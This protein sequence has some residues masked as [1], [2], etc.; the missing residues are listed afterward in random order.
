[1]YKLTFILFAFFSVALPI[2]ALPVPESDE[3]NA[4]EKRVS[5]SGRVRVI[6]SYPAHGADL[7]VCR[8]PGMILAWETVVG[9]ITTINSSLLFPRQFIM[10]D[11]IAGRCGS[12]LNQNIPVLMSFFSL[13]WYIQ[14]AS[15]PQRR[16]LTVAPA[17]ARMILVSVI[18]LAH[19]LFPL[20]RFFPGRHVSCYVP[21]I[22]RPWNRCDF[23][24]V[25]L[26]VLVLAHFVRSSGRRCA[27]RTTHD[28]GDLALLFGFTIF[29]HII[30]RFWT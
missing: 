27:R 19:W 24:S 10:V 1:M 17:V 21:G 3:I 28:P 9:K 30:S 26:Y 15:R 13:F 16:S 20:I 23:D 4:L 8:E 18:T 12:S 5:Y 6:R 25:E 2:L 29:F 22:F 7:S 14:M 11:N